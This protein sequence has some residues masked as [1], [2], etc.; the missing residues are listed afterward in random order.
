MC[1]IAGIAGYKDETGVAR[2]LE[3]TAHRG[4]DDRGMFADELCTLGHNR[5]SIIDLSAAGHQPMLS[6]DKRY[7]MVY[8]GEI[9]NY[10]RRKIELEQLGVTFKSQSDSE[11]LL[12]LYI[13]HGSDCVNHLR[14]MFA[15]AIWDTQ[16]KT[17]F[18][19]RDRHG[20]KPFYYTYQNRI[21]QF[22]S[23]I[24]GLVAGGKADLKLNL[25]AI[26][27]FLTKGCV[28]PPH[29]FYK[30]IKSLL[31]GQS[32][33]WQNGKLTIDEFTKSPPAKTAE[34]VT[35]GEAVQHVYSLLHESTEEQMVSDVP[36]GIF[37][38]GGLDS[39]VLTC[40]AKKFKNQLDTFSL[41]F[42]SKNRRIDE[43]S[44]AQISAKYFGTTHHQITISDQDI[45]KHIEQFIH[46]VDQP[47]L[48]GIN[49]YFIS[50]Y[51]SSS[52]TVTLSGLGGDELFMGYS[53]Q[54]YLL[55]HT[56]RKAP[57]Q[58]FLNMTWGMLPDYLKRRWEVDYCAGNLQ[59]LYATVNR[60]FTPSEINLIFETKDNIL[61]V[62]AD[63][64]SDYSLHPIE[65][66]KQ[67]SL[68]DQYLFM[69]ARLREIDVTGMAWS[70]E[71]RFP[72]LDERLTNYLMT[73]PPSYLM[74]WKSDTSQTYENGHVKK[75][76]YDA[77]KKEL[78]A[79]FT[80]RSKKGFEMPFHSWLSE[81]ICG[82]VKEELN[83]LHPVLKNKEFLMNL[84]TEEMKQGGWMKNWSIFVLNFW[85]RK[86]FKEYSIN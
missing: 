84:L 24:K 67:I 71:T 73:L 47:S 2:M 75:L 7:V 21:L 70:I 51:S 50:H 57:G 18:A 49:S 66:E 6:S 80:T 53:S 52:V 82:I 59:K 29:T 36:L 61:D 14:G 9:Y 41:G 10:K 48:D 19:A 40:A 32:L 72:L 42:E 43:S 54:H 69:G 17:L 20:I 81:A 62:F 44:E 26:I 28:Y 1:S 58:K 68:M 76:L 33:I 39:S 77:F 34:H 85:L 16:E 3:A 5:L 37:L 11:V 60:V 55:N 46:T 65:P 25:T 38:S 12:Q 15:F 35:Y 27:Q 74:N 78:P 4:P 8:N 23:E 63:S 13:K 86:N 79:D 45:T 30:E 22:C 64:I 56:T 31:P 83:N